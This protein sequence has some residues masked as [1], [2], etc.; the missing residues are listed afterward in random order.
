MDRQEAEEALTLVRQV[1]N[2][3]HDIAILQNWGR[4]MVIMATLD[5]LAFGLTQVFWSRGVHALL[6]Y[7]L[8]WG[9]Y[10]LLALL[11]NLTVRQRLG[12]TNTYVERHIWANGL[13]FYLASFAVIGIDFCFFAPSEAMAVIPAHVAVTGAISFTFVALL[14]PRFLMC[15]AIFFAVAALVSWWSTYG[16]LVLGVAWFL[17]LAVPGLHYVAE[18]KRLLASGSYTETL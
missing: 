18:K 9:I 1:V 3:I 6:P 17:C 2:N 4:V 16:F 14:D 8:V 10:L 7:S 5:I 13:T 12:G 15:T 11:A